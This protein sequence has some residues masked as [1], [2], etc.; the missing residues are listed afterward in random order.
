MFSSYE[1]SN[2]MEIV[3][4]DSRYVVAVGKGT[5][6][7]RIIVYNGHYRIFED[8]NIEP[9]F[10]RFAKTMDKVSALS[11]HGWRFKFCQEDYKIECIYPDGGMVLLE[12]ID[13]LDKFLGATR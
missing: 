3:D 8:R 12:T 2:E 4:I 11:K 13:E 10:V 1:V 7:R 5:Y 9:D 6:K